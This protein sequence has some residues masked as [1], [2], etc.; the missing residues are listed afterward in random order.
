MSNDFSS[1]LAATAGPLEAAGD[2][3]V[4]RFLGDVAH[5]IDGAKAT[6]S[7]MEAALKDAKSFQLKAMRADTQELAREYA[8]A[9]ETALRR[10][11]T[12]A[13]SEGVVAEEA[14]AAMLAAGFKSVLG[15]LADVGVGLVKAV[16]SGI[17]SGTIKGFTGGAGFD[18]SSVFPFA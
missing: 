6:G 18:P 5:L 15:T 16:A 14:T 11:K 8:E 9:V 4:D 10:V 3:L 7:R 12:L 17:V 1:L 2:A 13:L